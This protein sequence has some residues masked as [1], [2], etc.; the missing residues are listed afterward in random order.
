MTKVSKKSAQICQKKINSIPILFVGIK[1]YTKN[2]L[3]GEMK[4][5]FDN[6]QLMIFKDWGSL[7]GLATVG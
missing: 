7:A 3:F 5:N 2:V 1:A 4:L 6:T